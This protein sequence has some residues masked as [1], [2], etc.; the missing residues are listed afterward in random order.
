MGAE[1]KLDPREDRHRDEHYRDGPVVQPALPLDSNRPEPTVL[2]PDPLAVEQDEASPALP[3]GDIPLDPSRS[4]TVSDVAPPSGNAIDALV[5]FAYKCGVPASVLAAPFAKDHKARLLTRVSDPLS[6]DRAAGMAIRAGHFLVHGVKAPIAQV[7]YGPASRL[8]PPF[9]R[10][11]HG[12]EWMRDLAAAASPKEGM[13]R[14]GELFDAWWRANPEIGKGDGWNA[15][16]AGRRLLNWLLHAE[17]LLAGH[18][19][20]REARLARFEETARWLDRKAGSAPDLL[21]Q[22]AGWA[23]VV[24][25]GLL[26]NDGKP[27]RLHGEAHFYRVLGDLVSEDGG[28]LSR[29]P[30]AQMQAI[31]LLVELRACYEAAGRDAPRALETMLSLLVP[32]LLALQHGDGGLGSWQGGAAISRAEL[33]GLIEASGVR[34]RP[35][36][37][38]REWGYQAVAA[39][40]TVLQFDA[41]PPPPSRH[42]RFACAGTLAFELSCGDNRIIVNCG[43]AALA[44]GQ[45]PVRIEQGLRATAAHST[46]TLD[47]AN[48]SAILI[49][50]QIGKGVNEVVIARSTVRQGERKATRLEA[51]HDG[52]ASRFGLTHRRILMLRDDGEELRGEDV[53]EPAGKRGKR[54]KIG[55]A[56]RFHLA[57]GVEVRLSE[58]GRGAG[59]VLSDGTHWQFRIGGDEKEIGLELDESLWVDGD[60]RPRPTRQLVVSGMTSRGGGSFPWLLKKIG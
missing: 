1:T 17:L 19:R 31:G 30:L 20:L 56:I 7:D 59:L 3:P 49:K 15:E 10:L 13:E 26:L 36:R 47:D 44:G 14:A 39:R 2:D 6:G 58:D 57:P 16:L 53:L 55:F 32:P 42:A 54:G 11:I 8:T 45:T 4:L 38:L 40:K 52:Y 43:G 46:L 25:A 23:A 18:E 33:V 22:A 29:S 24:A 34:T 35:A 28:V 27:R 9:T 5:R 60:G 48:S 37:D 12:F 50:G 51:S 41:A 21:G